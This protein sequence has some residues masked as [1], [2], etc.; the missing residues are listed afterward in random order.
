[1]ELNQ[2]ADPDASHQQISG[3]KNILIGAKT[4]E[5][6]DDFSPYAQTMDG[7]KSLVPCLRVNVLLAATVFYTLGFKLS[8]SLI[9]GY[10]YPAQKNEEAK[11]I[12]MLR[13]RWL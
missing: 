5:F 1:M 4:C 12:K 13:Q 2:T 3:V 10:D 7:S 6:H 11:L 8:L 9:G